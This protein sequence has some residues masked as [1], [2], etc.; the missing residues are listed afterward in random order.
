MSRHLAT[1][2]TNIIH[3]AERAE[4]CSHCHLKSR[5]SFC[6]LP[7]DIF[8]KL[9]PIVYP[10]SYSQGTQLFSEGQTPHGIFILCRGRVK[11][12][13]GSTNGKTLMRI[14]E[15]GEILGLSATITGTAYETTAAALDPGQVQFIR[16]DQFL[17]FIQTYGEAGLRAMQILSREHQTVVEQIRTLVLAD[18]AEQKL[19]NLLLRW[20]KES[21]QLTSE[22]IQIK[23]TLTHGE[24]AQMIGAAR[25]TV[26]RL[27]TEFKSRKVIRIEGSNLFIPNQVALENLVNP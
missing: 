5:F 4:Q 24:I 2:D 25:E 9:E 19:A 26:T 15:V 1:I 16:R 22:G 20:C 11:L 14:A 3:R 7:E 6:D 27:F 13:S 18:S 17:T 12:L 8:K 21:G 23:L 10:F